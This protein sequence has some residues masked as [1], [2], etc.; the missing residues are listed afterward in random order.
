MDLYIIRTI[1]MGVIIVCP[2]YLAARNG[3]NAITDRLEMLGLGMILSLSSTKGPFISIHRGF[4][5]WLCCI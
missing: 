5:L 4:H 2:Q 1:F 3:A